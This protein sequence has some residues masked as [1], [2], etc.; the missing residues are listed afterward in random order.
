MQNRDV[1]KLVGK[2]ARMKQGIS[3]K[4]PNDETPSG[5]P[6]RFRQPLPRNYRTI[7]QGYLQPISTDL[8]L[9]EW[10]KIP[11]DD[12]FPVTKLVIGID[13]GT[14]LSAVAVYID[15]ELM[16]LPNSIGELY[17]PS[18]VAIG[19]DGTPLIGHRATEFLKQ[20]PDRGVIEVKRLFGH[21]LMR[22]FGGP[23][24]LVVDGV[25]YSPVHLAAFILIK[26]RQDAEAHLQMKIKN[27]VL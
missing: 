6:S 15:D 24:V 11:L 8:K 2:L 25:A 7:S 20:N 19:I 9:Y 4:N 10:M 5:L 21:D 12:R 17:T 27:A 26:V 22:D 3:I 16:V 1:A 13:F 14:T 23:P 18:A